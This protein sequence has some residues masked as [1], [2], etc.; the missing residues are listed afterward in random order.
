LASNTMK[1]MRWLSLSVMMI[2]GS[3]GLAEERSALV[4]E[5]KIPLPHVQGRIDHLAID[6]EQ[7]RLFVAA[8]GND[9]VEVVDLAA[10]RV[11]RTLTGLDEPQGIAY[12]P[13]MK[14]LYVANGGDGSVRV[15][16]GV[17]LMPLAKINV[18][19]DADNVRIDQSAHEVY[20]GVG[21][22]AIAIVDEISQSVVASLPLKSHPESFQLATSSSAI[23]AN[24]PDAAE[25]AVLD[26]RTHKQVSAWPVGKL[27][28]NYAMALDEKNQRVLVSFRKPAT[29]VA[30]DSRSG[31]VVDQIATCDDADDLFVDAKRSYVYVACGE[32]FVDVFA[33][34][35]EGYVRIAHVKTI[36]GA[37]TALYSVELDMFFL[38]ARATAAEAASL[39]IFRMSEPR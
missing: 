38:A 33:L 12:Q 18:G 4:L 13:T 39:W 7:R 20:V 16:G 9:T 29:I 35:K 24:V 31:M 1:S 30:F 23:F 11:M 25:I 15:F 26:R 36:A 14:R 10:A 5:K 8:L 37:R 22:G 34:Q 28:A 32:G 6:V 27:H 2:L 17:D 21:A 3:A 19:A